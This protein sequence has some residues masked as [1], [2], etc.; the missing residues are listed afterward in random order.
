MFSLGLM[1]GE[2]M[3]NIKVRQAIFHGVNPE[4][5]LI[6][7]RN[8]DGILPTDLTPEKNIGSL[9][10]MVDYSNTYNP[11]LAKQLLAE[12][13]FDPATPITF[14]LCPSYFGADASA[15]GI[16][17]VNNLQEIG[18]NVV[19]ENLDGNVCT[20]K[21]L[22]GGAEMMIN[23]Q[24]SAPMLIT[25]TLNWY[26]TTGDFFGMNNA[27]SKSPEL[28]EAVN[29]MRY[30]LNE[31]DYK[32]AGETALKLFYDTYQVLPLYTPNENVV[33]NAQLKNVIVDPSAYG[34]VLAFYW[35]Y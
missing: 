8:G 2:T 14:T 20:E 23:K 5:A 11:E 32:A 9:T 18:F 4:D 3:D 7:A 28:D 35:S 29:A 17:I 10:G 30:A 12:S 22:S 6:A 25:D 19:T 31:A 24:G 13:G 16:S 15:A 26:T 33:Y 34:Y 27:T 1:K 21:W